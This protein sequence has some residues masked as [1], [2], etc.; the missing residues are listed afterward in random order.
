MYSTYMS[1]IVFLYVPYF[2]YDI[3]LLSINLFYVYS[4]SL[5][6]SSK[7]RFEVEIESRFYTILRK[8][9]NVNG[10]SIED[11]LIE[12]LIDLLEYVEPSL[13][14][15]LILNLRRVCRQYL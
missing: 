8:I 11:A 12:G 3:S 7:L 10:H 1:V 9:C 13:S 4:L 15:K 2:A 5:L 14:N 6:M